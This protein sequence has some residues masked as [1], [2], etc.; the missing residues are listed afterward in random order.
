MRLN[1]L[2]VEFSS[3]VP[4]SL[5]KLEEPHNWSEALAIEA[6]AIW[7]LLIVV[8]LVLTIEGVDEGT[9]AKAE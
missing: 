6:L 5:V 1:H 3:K 8:P 9:A 4:F 7:T 2:N